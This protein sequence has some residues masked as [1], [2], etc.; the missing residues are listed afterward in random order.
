MWREHRKRVECWQTW[1]QYVDHVTT[2][3]FETEGKVNTREAR[4]KFGSG[5]GFDRWWAAR[6]SA[7]SQRVRTQ[8]SDW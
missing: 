4:Q 1:L 7:V 8:L 3:R 2:A 5:Q 6:A